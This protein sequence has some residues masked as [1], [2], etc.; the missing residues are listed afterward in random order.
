MRWL[1][2]EVV[3]APLVPVLHPS[4]LRMK[5]LGLFTLVGHPLFWFVWAVWLPQPYENL[6]LRIF[7][8]LLGLLLVSDRVSKDPTSRLSG[9]V[10]T[11]VFWFELPFLFSWMFWCNGGNHAWLASMAAMILTY[12]FA[13]DW[14]IATVGIAAGAF[15]SRLLFDA[16]GPAVPPMSAELFWTNTMVLAF[17]VSMGMLLGVSSANLRREHLA[18]T[19]ATM[20][21]MAHEL[22]TP[23]ATMALIGDAV[24]GSAG[25]CSAESGAKLEQLA[26]RLHT[27]VRN[28]NHQ[29]D[30][31]ITNAR[32]TRL[33]ARTETVSAEDLVRSAVANYPFRSSREKECVRLNVQHD[34]QFRGSQALF[35]QVID[36]LMKNALRSLAASSSAL[37]SGDLAIE[38]GVQQDRGRIVVADRGV[39]IAP[40]SQPRIFEPFFSTN[41]GTGHGLGLAFCHQV[42]HAARGSIR[43]RS[44]PGHGAVFTIELP[45]SRRA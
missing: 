19:L 36:N 41:R 31:Q 29:I 28:M 11:A 16:I 34:F 12:Y 45:V 4:P 30:M 44:A 33:P 40:D 9:Q 26:M 14:R 17:C 8:A 38:V 23:L 21:I 43:V 13:T 3:T 24:R 39:G 20:G 35:L 2:E 25:E 32:L 22:R 27:L 5:G 15:L 42:V 10:F 7:T 6:P 1:K 18:H 37:Q